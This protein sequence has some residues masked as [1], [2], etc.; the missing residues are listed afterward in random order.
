LNLRVAPFPRSSGSGSDR[1]VLE[2]PQ[3]ITKFPRFLRSSGSAKGGSPGRPGSW[4]L[5]LRRRLA[6]QDSL[7]GFL[8]FR[9]ALRVSPPSFLCS[10]PLGVAVA[11]VLGFPLAL[12]INGWVDD[13]SPVDSNFASAAC[14]V[15]ESS[16]QSG[17]AHPR[18][19]LLIHSPNSI[20][21]F[22]SPGCPASLPTK[23]QLGSCTVLPSSELRSQLPCLPINSKTP[24]THVPGANM[25]NFQVI[26]TF[27]S[28]YQPCGESADHSASHFLKLQ[29]AA[30]L[31]GRP[32][33]PRSSESLASRLRVSPDPLPQ[34]ELE[35]IPRPRRL[36]H[37]FPLR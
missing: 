4:P 22:H 32:G 34:L 3:G 5:R 31:R 12:Q 27:S 7:A 37:R 2:S 36:H 19:A 8:D 35:R 33:I 20:L 26:R 18:L 28:P 21:V 1:F 30:G 16:S 25:M 15:D 23:A 29:P 6:P 17:I 10:L 9:I 11:C 14:A 24:G 13:D